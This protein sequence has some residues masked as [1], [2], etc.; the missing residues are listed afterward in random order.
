MHIHTAVWRTRGYL[1]DAFWI[2][3]G[4]ELP[5][6]PSVL[7]GLL[8]A[9]LLSRTG[10]RNFVQVVP[11]LV[12]LATLIILLRPIL[13]RRR[14]GDRRATRLR[15][16][17]VAYRNGDHFRVV[18]LYGGYF[19]ARYR[20]SDDVGAFELHFARRYPA[21]GCAEEIF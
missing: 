17:V 11:W 13:V 16:G 4:C 9:L 12:V 3:D 20:Y 18:A 7:G 19:G 10:D 5:S 2:A 1:A 14:E 8:G 15:G 21:R 6:D